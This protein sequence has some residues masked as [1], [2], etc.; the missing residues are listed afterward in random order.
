MHG[1]AHRHHGR[2]LDT[3]KRGTVGTRLDI[4]MDNTRSVSRAKIRAGEIGYDWCSVIATKHNSYVFEETFIE[5]GRL[6][7]NKIFVSEIALMIRRWTG[8][9]Q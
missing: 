8:G 4:K 3:A 5:G 7:A 9:Q 6:Q 1:N 2:T